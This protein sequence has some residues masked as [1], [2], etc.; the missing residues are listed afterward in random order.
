MKDHNWAM[1]ERTI[2]SVVANRDSIENEGERAILVI[3]FFDS[4][5]DPEIIAQLKE[6]GLADYPF[7]QPYFKER[8]G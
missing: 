1:I 3:L 6:K 4:L 8:N 7:I 5:I 2:K